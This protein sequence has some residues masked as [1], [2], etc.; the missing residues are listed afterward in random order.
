MPRIFA[1][2]ALLVLAV[3]CSFDLAHKTACESQSDCLDGYVC[4]ANLCTSPT[5]EGGSS[6]GATSPAGGS[7][8]PAA[9]GTDS[10]VGGGSAGAAGAVTQGGNGG[11]IGV[12]EG[13]TG[14][15]DGGVGAAGGEAGG[16]D[17][18]GGNGDAGGEGG[19]G[20][21]GCVE[22]TTEVAYLLHPNPAVSYLRFGA[23]VAIDGDT[24]VVGALRDEAAFVFV[25]KDCGWSFQAEL[26][27]ADET[28]EMNF[29]NAVAIQGD[30][31]VVGAPFA[32]VTPSTGG[33]PIKAGAVYV[34]E[35]SGDSWSQTQKLIAHNADVG[36]QF[37]A[38]V[39]IDGDTMVIGA[40]GEDSASR[41]LN[42]GSDDNS[43]ENDGAAYVFIYGQGHWGESTYLKRAEGSGGD[44][45]WGAFGTSVAISGERLV[46]G[47]PG[48]NAAGFAN[49][50]AAYVFKRD[51]GLWSID[52]SL[53]VRKVLT[54]SEA[55][56]GFGTSVGLSGD[57]LAVGAP[58]DGEG[59]GQAYGTVSIFNHL[60][61]GG[62]YALTRL[63]DFARSGDFGASLA[64]RP[65]R[66]IVGDP[67]ETNGGQGI[68]A[69]QSESV[70][71]AV[72]AAYLF[73]L[74]PHTWRW[75]HTEYIKASNAKPYDQFGT[76]VA[77]SGDTFVVGAPERHSAPDALYSPMDKYR[78]GPGAAYAF[79]IAP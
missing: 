54:E 21:L 41:T 38:S 13:A 77:L 72:G 20:A 70:S 65:G 29:A 11:A 73:E 15:A 35:R 48:T 67:H 36:D 3:G 1:N 24:L 19:H 42:L 4:Q 58:N 37:G 10:A 59:T 7:N 79:E 50:G 52:E 60:Q 8:R 66:L 40:L 30:R 23:A 26:D 9:G 45:P 31:I 18:A 25:K 43:I 69:E 47:S 28:Q 39:A 17:S 53:W 34:F 2:T 71:I 46:V 76:S 6:A 14:G 12:S 75:D 27:P 63:G 44:A 74:D 61:G 51:A 55:G 78:L 57:T 64:L 56:V 68:G 62:W 22:Q 32:Q 33:D 16:G 5:A 49:T